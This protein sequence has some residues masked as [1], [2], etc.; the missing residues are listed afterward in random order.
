MALSREVQSGKVTAFAALIKIL[1]EGKSLPLGDS[2]KS[3]GL[4]RWQ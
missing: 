1:A 3:P 2:Q 4:E